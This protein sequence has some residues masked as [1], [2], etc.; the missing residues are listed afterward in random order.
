MFG[1]A[2]ERF[3]FSPFDLE[4][5]LI[6]LYGSSG[7][8]KS[9]GIHLSL[10]PLSQRASL[11]PFALNH[12]VSSPIKPL[13]MKTSV[14]SFICITFVKMLT[15]TSGVDGK[16]RGDSRP[17]SVASFNNAAPYSHSPSLEQ[18]LNQSLHNHQEAMERFTVC[19][20]F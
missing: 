1:D 15:A 10:T 8:R 5:V 13:C 9:F 6:L 4:N 19:S 12:L 7:V 2:I 3:S 20:L 16:R 18:G 11:I 17:A 14:T